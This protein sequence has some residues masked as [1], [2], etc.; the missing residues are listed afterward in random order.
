MLCFCMVS[1]NALHF[2]ILPAF[3]EVCYCGG[4]GM[5]FLNLVFSLKPQADSSLPS[6]VGVK[7]AK[8]MGWD[9]N[10]LLETALS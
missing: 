1:V 2:P 3:S 9:K 8:M 4:L 6:P 7:K 5:V 10:S